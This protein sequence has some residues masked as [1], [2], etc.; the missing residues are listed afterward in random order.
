MNESDLPKGRESDRM[1]FT[2]FVL[3][4][5]YSYIRIISTSILFTM[6]AQE[7][8]YLELLGAELLE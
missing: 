2:D 1:I 6:W 5:M 8:E 7:C 3:L 4:L